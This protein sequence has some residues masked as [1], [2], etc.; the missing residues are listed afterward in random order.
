M[1]KPSSPTESA[2]STECVLVLVIDSN[3]MATQLLCD[4]LARDRR[5]EIAQ[6]ELPDAVKIKPDV[7]LISSTLEGPE[8]NGLEFAHQLLRAVPQTRVIMMVEASTRDFVL[9]AFRAGARGIFSRSNCLK[10]LSK[11]ILS[12]HKGQ[13]WATNAEIQ[14]LL[15]ALEQH[16]PIRLMDAKGTDLLS[17]R[18]RDVVRCVTE[19]LTNRDIAGSLRLSEHTVK[20]YLFR[21]FNKLGVSSRVE[22]ILYALH[23]P[24]QKAQGE[25]SISE[26]EAF[27]NSCLQ[28][29]EQGHFGLNMA[30]EKH[31]EGSNKVEAL[32]W[33]IAA[34]SLITESQKRFKTASNELRNTMDAQ[35]V[36]EAKR[37]ALIWLSRNKTLRSNSR[38]QPRDPFLCVA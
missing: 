24:A 37:R 7:A 10:T 14:F 19:G 22:L 30:G 27:L 12:V 8:R 6:G 9:A 33:F 31:P 5:F 20:N 29:T 35:D 32:A 18:E 25:R 28:A 16:A 36:A 2:K 1:L 13:L 15:E 38:N 17:E 23:Q 26:G 4:A 34:G 11:C 21:I 3:R